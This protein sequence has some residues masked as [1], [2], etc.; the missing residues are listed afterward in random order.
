MMLVVGRQRLAEL[1]E[2]FFLRLG[3]PYR[4][5][6]E[7]RAV[8]VARAGGTHRTYATTAQAELLAAL[9]AFRHVDLD[10][11]FKC[12]HFKLATERSGHDRNRHRAMQIIA[13]ALK[14]LV[15]LD[16]DLHVA[17]TTFRTG[18]AGRSE[19]HTSEI[20]SLKH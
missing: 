18:I 14:D 6:D 19:E 10:L 1:L 9:R 13:L 2:Q 12:R 7:Y 8:Q 11:A 4:R 17:I 3:Q 15:W 20:Q 5:F 16:I